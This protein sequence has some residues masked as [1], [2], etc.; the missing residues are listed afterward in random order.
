VLVNVG[1]VVSGLG[2]PFNSAYV[3]SKWAIR[4]LSECLRAELH[5]APG[6]HVCTVMP[7]STDTPLFQQAANYTGRAT[8]AMTPVASAETVAAAIVAAAERRRREVIVGLSGR[9]AMLGYALAPRLFS[10]LIARE[11][12]DRHFQDKAAAPGHGNLFEPSAGPGCVGGGW[13]EYHRRAA[14]LRRSGQ[15]LVPSAPTAFFGWI[16]R[17]RRLLG[18]AE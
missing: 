14:K 18:G 7:A 1:S 6:V 8:Q 16:R 17:R 11:V 13:Q 3:V 2:V 9:V 10:R 15:P 12:A 5:D 4:G